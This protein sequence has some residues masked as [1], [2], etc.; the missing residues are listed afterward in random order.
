[1]S[2]TNP[3]IQLLIQDCGCQITSVDNE[4]ELMLMKR[5]RAYSSSCSQITLVC[6]YP[7]RRNSLFCS[8][9]SHKNH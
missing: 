6:L 8:W 7:F 3:F 4:C 1:M 9:K 5:A 2:E